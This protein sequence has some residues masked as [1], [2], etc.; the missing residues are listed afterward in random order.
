MDAD[1]VADAYRAHRGAVHSYLIRRLGQRETA[2]DLTAETF[3]RALA[4]W[5]GYTEQGRGR[6]PWLMS[7][8]RNILLD[9]YKSSRVRR[10]VNVAEPDDF[11]PLTP[12]CWEQVEHALR[13][14]TV[15]RVLVPLPQKYRCCLQLRFLAGLSR[16]ETA[17][18]LAI[19]PRAAAQL[20]VRALDA[21][22]R[23]LTTGALR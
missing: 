19:T 5:D 8:A 6:G 3:A 23:H 15:E 12:D 22:R 17:Q 1:E 13:R 16:A 9:H 14:E 20:Q 18:Q 11:G 2:E 10:E 4:H 21:A 7:I